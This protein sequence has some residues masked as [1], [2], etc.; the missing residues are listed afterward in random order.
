MIGFFLYLWV[1]LILKKYFIIRDLYFFFRMIVIIIGRLFA[2]YKLPLTLFRDFEI[3]ASLL[4]SA[5]CIRG[6]SSLFHPNSLKICRDFNFA[7]FYWR[8]ADLQS[9]KIIREMIWCVC[10][11]IFSLICRVIFIGKLLWFLFLWKKTSHLN[12]IIRNQYAPI[13]KRNAK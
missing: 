12:I 9:F 11:L 5:N 13:K 8:R 6:T 1:W 7:L 2:N 10:R 3:W 4:I